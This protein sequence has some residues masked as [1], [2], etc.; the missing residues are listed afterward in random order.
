MK[1]LELF[2]LALG[3]IVCQ[4]AC[5]TERKTD[6][7]KDSAVVA[8]LTDTLTFS[9]D[10]VRV[11]PK[12]PVSKNPAVTDTSK[13]VITYPVFKDQ[14][15]NNF[16]L[17]KIMATADVDKKYDNYKAY[18]DDFI[19]GF[20]DFATKEKDYQQTWFLN[21]KTEVL[22]QQKG[23]I[24]L[25][26]TY[27]NYSGGA[28]PNSV[29]SYLNYNPTRHQEILLDSLILPGSMTKLNTIA[30]GIFRKQEKL[31]P[32]ASLRDGYFFE[33]DRFKLNNNFTITEKGLEFLYNP[34]EIK[35]YVYGTTTLII[36]F[37]DLKGIARPNSLIS[38]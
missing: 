13:A 25:K 37:V 14:Q 19:K 33:N 7:Q 21:I 22:R 27:V 12:Q 31:A 11:F 1:K 24:A 10:S 6:K 16:V 15:L 29:F 36:P 20:E 2:S 3:I 32:A 8:P 35:A 26:T 17:G 9:Y 23:Y 5:Q 28:H 4:A 30:E 18:A 38:K 34:Y